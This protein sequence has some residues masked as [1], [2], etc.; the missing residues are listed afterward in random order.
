[1]LLVEEILHQ[2]LGSLSR[3]LQGFIHF[4]WCRISSINS[5][6]NQNPAPTVGSCWFTS[7]THRTPTSLQTFFEGI[8]GFP[9]PHEGH[10]QYFRYQLPTILLDTRTQLKIENGYPT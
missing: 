2:L 10:Q 5:T 9:K 7:N 6:D 4:R 3:Y 1:M 8:P